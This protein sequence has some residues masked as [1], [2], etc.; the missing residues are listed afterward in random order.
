ML[1]PP[2][3]VDPDPSSL[4]PTSTRSPW[5]R[6]FKLFQSKNRQ[7]LQKSSLKVDGEVDGRTSPRKRSGDDGKPR[8]IYRRP[9]SRAAFNQRLSPNHMSAADAARKPGRRKSDPVNNEAP[10][11]P[12]EATAPSLEP[13]NYRRQRSCSMPAVCHPQGFR[14]RAEDIKKQTTFQEDISIVYYEEDELAERVVQSEDDEVTSDEV[15]TPETSRSTT[16]LDK[17][18]DVRPGDCKE[19]H[20]PPHFTLGKT[21]KGL[22]IMMEV[23]AG[24][25]RRKTCVRAMSGGRTLVVLTYKEE[26]D[27]LTEHKDVINLPVNIDPFSVKANMLRSGH[28][29]IQAP[30]RKD[31]I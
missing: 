3:P 23:D 16:E 26:Q 31:S 4:S 27:V 1:A 6:L 20:I 25:V 21:R 2:S 24:C 18:V 28:L 15:S 30:L 11:L 7:E 17:C 9:N 13:I 22:R 10:A 29:C 8:N 5:I 19:I 12:R 14:R